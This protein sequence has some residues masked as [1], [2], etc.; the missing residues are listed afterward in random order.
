MNTLEAPSLF[1]VLSLALYATRKVDIV[2]LSLAWAY[3]VLRIGHS[4]IHL[5][6]NRVTH[7]VIPFAASNFVLIAMWIIFALSLFRL[8]SD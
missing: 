6:Y 4:I 8:G 2:F 5:T 7:R 1:H 3:V